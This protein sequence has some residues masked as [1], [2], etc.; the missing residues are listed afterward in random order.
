MLCAIKKSGGLSYEKGEKTIEEIKKMGKLPA[1]VW[2]HV[3]TGRHDNRNQ[4]DVVNVVFDNGKKKEILKAS[5]TQGWGSNLFQANIDLEMLLTKEERQTI[6]RFEN[7]RNYK[8]VK[9]C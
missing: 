5:P 7:I 2:L 8:I 6:N 3:E 9:W 4:F 1:T